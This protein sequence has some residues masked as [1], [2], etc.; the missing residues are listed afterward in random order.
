[1]VVEV[2]S[3][4]IVADLHRDEDHAIVWLPDLSHARLTDPAAA[5]LRAV[6]AANVACESLSSEPSFAPQGVEVN[7]VPHG[8]GFRLEAVETDELLTWLEAFRD[9]LEH[10][11][12]SGSVGPF[13]LSSWYDYTRGP[14]RRATRIGLTGILALSGGR[15]HD[16]TGLLTSW[17]QPPGIAEALA[18]T[19]IDWTSHGP[20]ADFLRTSLIS[21]LPADLRRPLLLDALDG[22][23]AY[24]SLN[25]YD[26][27]TRREATLDRLLGHLVLTVVSIVLPR[28]IRAD[29]A[30]LAELLTPWA[31]RSDWIL[32]GEAT[33]LSSTL[34][35]S[36]DNMGRGRSLPSCYQIDRHLDAEYVPDAFGW[37]ILTGQH[38]AKLAHR[39]HWDIAEV[40]PDR[41]LVAARDLEIWYPPGTD[42]EA[43]D[44]AR[45][46]AL[47]RAREDFHDV[48]LWTNPPEWK[49]FT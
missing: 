18:G 37:Q 30:T 41:Y 12:W 29:L 6:T 20:G 14:I 15:R 22:P 27:E 13:A 49:T 1:M 24:V 39:E 47:A 21:D 40:V 33:G 10:E 4:G 8:V 26:H 35:H 19:C 38:L 17:P 3:A 28:S 5:C 36:Y 44:A 25:R 2:D 31:A 7:T 34:R 42:P 16:P 11:G 23:S 9:A 45:F 48:I 46:H 43:E 32:I